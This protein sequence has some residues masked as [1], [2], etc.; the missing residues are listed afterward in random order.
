MPPWW[1]HAGAMAA[2]MR[3]FCK[4]CA[5]PQHAQGIA[6]KRRYRSNRSDDLASLADL[7]GLIGLAGLASL[8]DLAG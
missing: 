3:R 6:C 4:A 1:Q 5:K 2:A 7:A 8:V